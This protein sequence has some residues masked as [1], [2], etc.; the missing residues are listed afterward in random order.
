MNARLDGFAQ[1]A[2]HFE[3][4]IGRTEPFDALVRPLVIVILD[5]QP[6]PFPSRLEAFELSAGQKLLPD[7][8]PE[9][10][11][12]AQG[13]G[14]MRAGLEVMSPVLLH[15]GLEASGA[16]PVDVLPAVVGEHLF[17]R[18]IF[19]GRDPENL[20]DIFGRVAAEQI[21]AHDEARVIVQEADEVGITAAQPEGEDVGLPHLVGGGPLEEP[22]PDQV[23]PRPGWGLDQPLLL[24]GLAHRFGAGRQQEHPSQQLGYFL[25][26]PGGFLLLEFED[27]VADRRRQPRP[28]AGTHFALESR[29][30]IE[31][32]S[33]G[34]F[35]DRGPADP[36]FLGDQFLRETLFEVELDGAQALR[37]GYGQ[38]FSRRSPPRGG[39]VVL[40]LY[41]FILLHADT[42]YH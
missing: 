12:L 40:L 24:E 1:L 5:P 35:V 42:F 39:W 23:A 3:E 6:D 36:H 16:P 17:G 41:R 33:L 29:L 27:L 28:G 2:R 10:F 31:P 20:Q 4:P 18:L 19:A 21:G 34:P 11:D 9:P 25:D 37:E 26:A 32:K 13:H 7:R 8:L 14:V 38:A 22:G 15:L 30:A